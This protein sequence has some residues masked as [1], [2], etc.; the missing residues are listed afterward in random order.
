MGSAITSIYDAIASWDINIKGRTIPVRNLSGL[1]DA[2]N[3]GDA[4]AR[5]MMIM[6]GETEAENAAFLALGKLQTI[7]WLIEDR[8]YYRPVALGQGIQDYAEDLVVYI[9]DYIEA[10]RQDR[11]PTTQSVIED[12]RCVPAIVLWP[13]AEG[14]TPYAGVRCIL[15][16]REEVT[17]A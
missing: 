15:R 1:R 14:G 9:K 16:V 3:E 6:T 12:V 11:S 7:T 5:M 4:P 8:L 10:A 17:G 2:F 13:D